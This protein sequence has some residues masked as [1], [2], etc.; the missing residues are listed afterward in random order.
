MENQRI[1]HIANNWSTTLNDFMNTSFHWECSNWLRKGR[2]FPVMPVG[3]SEGIRHM[4]F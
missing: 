4:M 3:E 1:L 2:F